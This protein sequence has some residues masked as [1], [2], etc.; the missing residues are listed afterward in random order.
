MQRH[1]IQ[2]RP[3]IIQLVLE[4][5]GCF[6]G[7]GKTAH[8]VD[9][10]GLVERYPE[11]SSIAELNDIPGLTTELRATFD[12]HAL[13]RSRGAPQQSASGCQEDARFNRLR[14]GCRV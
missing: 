8:G 4:T 12:V 6:Q 14:T 10:V 3:S 7:T 13:R 2:I 1:A 5:G 9:I 11:D